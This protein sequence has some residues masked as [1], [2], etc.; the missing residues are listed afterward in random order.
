LPHSRPEHHFPPPAFAVAVSEKGKALHI[1]A[2]IR[3]PE[4]KIIAELGELIF[5]DPETRPW[6]TADAYLSGQVRAKLAAERAAS[7]YARNAEALRE[8]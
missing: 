2:A 5:H 7:D 4:E 3:R 1:L 8:V 6:Q